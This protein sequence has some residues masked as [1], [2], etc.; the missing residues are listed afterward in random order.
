MVSFK[1]SADNGFFWISYASTREIVNLNSDQFIA[2]LPY[3][4]SRC[5]A[6]VCVVDAA[7]FGRMWCVYE[8][9]MF[10]KVRPGGNVV[11]IYNWQCIM[12][13]VIF[14]CQTVPYIISYIAAMSAFDSVVKQEF[15]QSSLGG[16]D[17]QMLNFGVANHGPIDL[18]TWNSTNLDF[19]QR[20]GSTC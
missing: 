2:Y 10:L 6:I 19:N 11:F 8:L 14:A 3:I 1:S 17:T 7:Y 9:A 12:F 16:G 5:K 4:L 13:L 15:L 18:A 20:R